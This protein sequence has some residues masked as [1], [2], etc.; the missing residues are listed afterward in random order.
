MRKPLMKKIGCPYC[1]RA[2]WIS[3]LS[4]RDTAK[5]SGCGNVYWI[6]RRPIIT[7]RIETRAVR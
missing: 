1:G 3:A 5:C 7:H 2:R 6:Y 4:L